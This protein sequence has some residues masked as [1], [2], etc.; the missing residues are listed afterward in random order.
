MPCFNP[1]K[2]YASYENRTKNG[3]SVIM[4]DRKSSGFSRPVMLPCGQCIGCRIERSKS[5]ALRCIHE[6]STFE[7]NCF[8]TLTFNEENV[9]NGSLI[10]SDFQKFMK[11][12]RKRFSGEKVVVTNGKEMRPIRFFHCGEYGS[13][14]E[15]PHHHACLF[16]FDFV[17]KVIWSIRDGV[18]LYRSKSLEE[19]WPYGFCTVGDVTWQSAAYVARYITK[20]ITGENAASHYVKVD[21]ESGEIYHIEPEYITMSRRP[22]IGKNWFERFKDDAFP[23]DFITHRGK[24]FKVPAYY[25]KLYD[26]VEP[27]NFHKVKIKRLTSAE[28]HADNNTM[29][30]LD[31][32]RKCQEAK[33]KILRRSMEN[34][35]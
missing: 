12:L 25:D 19:L 22:G 32:R 28:K 34:A 27:E 10:K 9:G 16:N 14:L 6:A 3:K 4:F 26:S 1:I 29:W 18:R 15:R 17:D 20:K 30:R 23:K 2:A 8:I 35:D 11:R 5:W 33:V 13:K 7:S 24:K 31:V 21:N